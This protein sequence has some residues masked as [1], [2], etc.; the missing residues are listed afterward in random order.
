MRIS[1]FLVVFAGFQ[2]LAL[3]NYAQIQKLELKLTNVTITEVLERIEDQT[4]FFF[5]YN[6][7]GL[8][9][10][11]IVSLD[12][13]DKTINEV[14]DVLFKDTNVS[15]TI[16]NRQIILT[17]SETGSVQ[18]NKT[19]SG[20][21]SDS[22]GQPLPGVSVVV[23]GTTTGT[24][25]DF[26]GKY[27]LA[28]VPGDAM[29]VFS[30]VGMKAQE[31]TVA[32]KNA[33]DITLNEET[34]GI[35]EV[36]AI[37]YGT[38]KKENLTGSVS[39][40]NAESLD[41]R[42]VT[43][44]AQ[45]LQGIAPGLNI[46]QGGSL[47]GSLENRP[48]INIRGIGTIGQGS[49]ATPLIL[50]DGIEGDLNA[51]NP[52]DIDNISVLKDAAASSIYGSRAP[53]GVVLITT[54]KGKVGKSAFNINA[55]LRSSGPVLL[56]K[57]MDSYTFALYFNDARFNSGQGAYF[58]AERMQRI[59]DYQEGKITTTIVPRPGQPNLWGDGYFEGNDNVDWYRAIYKTHT[60]SQEYSVS[61]SG[62]KENITY[63][64]G[65]SYLD[66]TGLM[67]FGGDSF[68]RYN[69]TAKINGQLTKWMSV[70]YI[71][72]FVREEF[73]RPSSMTNTL[74][75]NIARQ[76][77]PVLP[78]Y[79]NNGYLY[80][81][82]SPALALQDG[83]RGNKQTDNIVQ[84]L[85]LT[86]EP[87]KGWK[88]M[89]DFNYSIRDE[90]YHWDLLYT[91]NHDVEGNPYIAGKSSEV[92]EVASR[93]N[94]SNSN[95]YTEY[96]KSIGDHNLKILAG[97][98]SELTKTRTFVAERE[99]LIVP[100]LPVID[101][102]SG[103]DFKGN[104]V[105]PFVSG[106]NQHWSTSGYFGRINYN[107][108]ERYLFEANLRYDGSSR[109]R[110]NKRWTYSPSA[111]V[112]WNIAREEFWKPISKYVN[113]LKLRGSYGVLSN[114]N[115]SSWYPTYSTMPIGISNG[116]WLV[117]GAKPNTASAPYLIS[118]ALTWE[119]VSTWN[120]GADMG[121]LNNRLSCTF[122][123][124]A[125]YTNDMVGPAPELPV[126]LGTTVPKTNN[127]D[128][129]TSGF[130]L[131][132][133]WK[134]RL[135]NGLNYNAR[136][137]LSDSKTEIT[138]YPNP[139]GNLSTYVE[140]HMMGEIWGYQTIGIAKTQEEMDAHLASL[141][142]GG[143]NAL[144]SNWKAGDLMY[145][146]LN[147]DGKINGGAGTA[148][149]HGD[150]KIIGNDTPRYL[151]GLDLSANWRGFDFRSFFQ[152]VLKRDYFQNSFYFWGAS[153]TIYSSA[154]LKE[155]A[156][157]FRDDPEHPL[158]LNLDSYYPRPLLSNKNQRVQ[159]RYLQDASY[160][161]LKN[162]Q[163]GYTL[164]SLLT[165][166]ISIQKL[167]VYVSGEN[168]WTVTGMKSMFDPETID[169]GWGG[170]VYPLSKVYSVGLNITL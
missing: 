19:V 55:N 37:G 63:Y 118:S 47:A 51:L 151:F 20:K 168:I 64:L 25:T 75:Q 65:G 46:T 31:V 162:I 122:D 142:N 38:Q 74:N 1:I 153:T 44:V 9:L 120:I 92:H 138:K 39:T 119:K 35:E 88:I 69:S 76:G 45:A 62:G 91:Y 149:D 144:G 3:S 24:I 108:K 93:I 10:E 54:K 29:L 14:L 84:Q 137:V 98:Q 150:W 73:E 114:Q 156:D 72:R 32:G 12:L 104:T 123:L 101:L 109:F 148:G 140:G 41:S 134:D 152:G 59:K 33:I 21:V 85:Q 77:W 141:P 110:S 68:R 26:D 112:G 165:R 79:D 170:S 34:F 158:G 143:Q 115:T 61:A 136:F 121:F 66:Q 159:T 30:F 87:L 125:R 86:I 40:V 71:G 80:D 99:G 113:T 164:P 18:Q 127:T 23:K 145:E 15:Y 13:K 48:S 117:N 17:G 78:L 102:T 52:Q 116:T 105:P 97:M 111:S 157:Y 4:D 155:H 169:G 70:E 60:P 56:P 16:N 28:N 82:P 43:N 81:A 107:Y 42:P 89:G 22:S 132:L 2:A 67:K 146:D 8:P 133:A 6:N 154:G 27:T 49:K 131:E 7:K 130:E 50:I 96:S 128:L 83:G 167:R 126:I 100:S 163:I 58:T 135:T 94:Y 57:M 129:K 166:K 36:V 53:F 103:T 11:K 161:R 90:F 124:F 139:T 106:E 5:F 95:F 147:D 160:I